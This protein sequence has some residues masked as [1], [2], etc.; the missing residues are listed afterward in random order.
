MIIP[1]YSSSGAISDRLDLP[2]LVVPDR[3]LRDEGTSYH[4]LP[5]ASWAYARGKLADIVARHARVCGSRVHRGATWTTDAPYRETRTLIEQHCANGIL[6]VEMEAALTALAEARGA[7][8]A[9]LLH[10]TNALA[11]TDANA[12]AF[13][14]TIIYSNCGHIHRSHQF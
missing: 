10:V 3:A 7:D 9:S 8:L 1:F 4:Y 6:T 12:V 5:P 2:C 14:P 13:Q 11:T